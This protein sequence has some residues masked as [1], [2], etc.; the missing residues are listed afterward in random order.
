M[1]CLYADEV[2]VSMRQPET[3]FYSMGY[4]GGER[5]LYGESMCVVCCRCVCARE[6]DVRDSLIMC[7]P[8]I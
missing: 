4:F 1:R 7:A 2:P 5:K 8:P 3:D 6:G